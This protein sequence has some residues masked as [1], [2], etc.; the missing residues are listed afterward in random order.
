MN[1]APLGVAPGDRHTHACRASPSD[2]LRQVVIVDAGHDDDGVVGLGQMDRVTYASESAVET[3][4]VLGV[5]A[6][7]RVHIPTHGAS[8]TRVALQ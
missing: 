5:G 2:V 7:L 6:F 3:A 4:P 1:T 8:T